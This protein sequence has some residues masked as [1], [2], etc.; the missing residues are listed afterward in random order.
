MGFFMSKKAVTGGEIITNFL[1]SVGVKRCFGV[2]GESYLAVLD[3]F[4]SET[5]LKFITCRHEGGA[6][7]MAEAHAKLTGELGVCFVTRGPGACNGSIGVHTA[8]QDSSPLFYFIGQV[9]TNNMGREA[10]QEIDYEKM[11]GSVAK[12]AVQVNNIDRLPEILARAYSVATSGRKGP[13][14]IALPEDILTDVTE[15]KPVR[16]IFPTSFRASLQ[17]LNDVK[18]LLDNATKPILILGGSGWD[19]Q[20]VLNVNAFSEKYHIP[21]VTSFRRSDLVLASN[22]FY[23]GELGFANDPNLRD[24][25]DEADCIILLGTRLSEVSSQNYTLLQNLPDAVVLIH[26]HPDISELNK[27]HEVTCAIC[28]NI[29]DFSE[30]IL[31]FHLKADWAD[32]A[33]QK[34]DLCTDWHKPMPLNAEELN[35]WNVCRD[36][37]ILSPKDAIFTTDAGNFAGWIQ[38]YLT[39]GRPRR[40]LGPTNGAMGYSVPSAIAAAL[41]AP[42]KQV[43]SCVGDGGFLMTCTELATA[44][45]QNLHNLTILLF[46]NNMYGTIR[47]HQEIHYPERISG[48]DLSNPDFKYLSKSF[49]AL[50]DVVEVSSDFKKVFQQ[51]LA[52]ERFSVIELRIRPE[53][54]TTSKTLQEL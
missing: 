20:A 48:T 22:R 4:Y 37:E 9:E 17:N 19:E 28:S 41:A 3:A 16:K 44:K 18:N 5:E 11:F 38:R 54:I 23:L 30:D 31:S 1:K 51:H 49:N 43:I 50:Y 39:L 42:D 10:F 8:A 34:V 26:I 33:F 40:L 25:I 53:Q 13:V 14:V 2:P 32:W 12:W 47:M 45:M 6:A 15:L 7:F 35:L 27:T 21:L 36:L 24:A 46:N 52:A 29:S